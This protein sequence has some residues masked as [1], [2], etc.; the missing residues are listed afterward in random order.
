MDHDGKPN[1]EYYEKLADRL[2]SGNI[3]SEEER[4]LEQWYEK[5]SAEDYTISADHAQSSVMHE[6]FLLEKIRVRGNI[7]KKRFTIKLRAIIWTGA[8]A[9]AIL[10]LV[11]VST[12]LFRQTAVKPEVIQKE[13]QVTDIAPGHN[14]AVL[15]LSNGTKVVLDSLKDGMVVEQGGVKIIKENGQLKYV[16][17]SD[18]IVYNDIITERGRQWK[19]VLP[20]GTEVWLNAASKLHYP[21]SF[22]GQKERIVYLTGEAYFKVA[23]DAAQPFKVIA[24]KQVIEDIGTAFNVNAYGDESKVVTTLVEG[25]VKVDNVQLK[26]GQQATVTQ[27]GQIDIQQVNTKYF[28]AWVNGQLSLDNVTVKELMLQLSRWYDVDIVYKGAVPDI[29]LGGLIDRN[30]YLSDIISVLNAYGVHLN[31]MDKKLIISPQ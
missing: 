28:T 12:W 5:V 23:H 25:I 10:I 20:D 15:H 13:A 1:I 17:T 24:G 6:E 31:L 16:G 11:G 18:K 9:A 26:P 4:E 3:T 2:L 8:A 14:G 27:D 19:M 22:E 29:R 30:V 7:V 21:V